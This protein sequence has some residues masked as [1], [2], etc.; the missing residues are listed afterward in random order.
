MN[1]K[2]SKFR[3]KYK[4]NKKFVD[5]ENPNIIETIEKLEKLETLKVEH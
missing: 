3:K 5:I 4:S 1:K 2:K